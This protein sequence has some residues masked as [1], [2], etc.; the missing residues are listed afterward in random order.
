MHRQY[1]CNVCGVTNTIVKNEF[2]R[3]G[4][5]CPSCHSY[6]RLRGLMIIL[7]QLIYG[8]HQAISDFDVRKDIS[9]IGLSDWPG[10]ADRIK[11]KFNYINTHFQSPEPS[12][13]ISTTIEGY[14]E[15]FD[16]VIC[17]DVLE[18]VVPPVQSA[19]DNLL[20]LLK[21]GGTLIFSVP[22]N[23]E[24]KTTEHFPDLCTFEIVFDDGKPPKLRNETV[25]GEVQWFEDLIFHGAANEG[26][27][28]EM[29]TFCERDVFKHLHFAGFANIEKANWE[30]PE[31]GVRWIDNWS[32]PLVAQKPI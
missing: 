2:P 15:K 27:A 18:H 29:R 16:Y 10:Y 22:Y 31:F 23:L 8:K 26:A 20:R 28:L 3:E 9:I 14:E 5:S 17:S 11:K 13:D 7:S 24:E 12:L 21:P 25:D 30:S 1:V 32:L 6:V 19:F 4:Q